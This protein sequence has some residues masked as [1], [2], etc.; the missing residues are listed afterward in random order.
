MIFFAQRICS[1]K[2]QFYICRVKYKIV[3]YEF[4]KSR[5]TTDGNN[6]EA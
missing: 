1:I 2:N 5:R 4:V 3:E 6:L